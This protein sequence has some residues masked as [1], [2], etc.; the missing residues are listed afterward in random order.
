MQNRK[1]LFFTFWYP[2]KNNQNFAIFVKRHAQAISLKNNIVVLAFSFQH[3]KSV[4]LKE[5]ITNTENNIETH[6]IYISSRFWKLLYVCLPLHYLIAKK[7][8]NKTI[9]PGFAFDIIHSNI[10]FPCAIVGHKLSKHYRCKHIITEHWSKIDKF[11]SRSLYKSAGKKALDNAFAITCVSDFLVNIVKKHTA[12]KNLLIVPNVVNSS[13]FYPDTTI[14]K[15]PILTFICVAHWAPPKNPFY[16]TDALQALH[17]KH[18]LP[19]F[20]LKIAGEGQMLNTIKNKQY[21]YPIH[22]LG[23]LSP[24]D[25]NHEFNS[26]HIFLHGSDFETFS[27]VIVEALMC[28][29]PC[30]V[31]PVGIAGSVINNGN[32]AIAYNT[33]KDWEE[34]ILSC[35]QI[36]YYPEEISREITGKYNSSVIAELFDR[37]Y[38]KN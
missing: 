22:Y 11:F 13:Q 6:H 35:Y 15:E 36:T 5:I 19:P 31:S 8:I 1:I 23:N 34:K 10:L 29:L 37:L 21:T 27:V 30:V 28:G 16:F 26:S 24:V 4:Y 12:N 14:V 3:S 33:T 20:Q 17:T 25:L 7:Y 38:Q 18:K 9:R 2:N 32:G